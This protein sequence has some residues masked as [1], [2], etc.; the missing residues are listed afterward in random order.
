MIPSVNFHLWEPCNMRCKFCFAT[1]QD[2]KQSILPKGHLLKEEALS[3][4]ERLA[5]FGFQK[6]TFA[7]GEPTLCAWLPDLIAKAKDLGMTTMIVSNGSKL[8]DD[9]L[10]ENRNKLDWI[11]ISVDSVNPTIN[12]ETGRAVSGNTPL[13]PKD[14]KSIVDKVKRMGYG[15]KINTVVSSMN[16]REDMGAFI[17]YAQPERWKIL[18]VL[19]ILGQND[20]GIN[21]LQVSGQQFQMFLDTHSSLSDIT[22]IVPE[23]NDLVKGS[24]A[25][26]DPAGRFFDN[27]EG[28]HRYSGPILEIGVDKAWGG[29][30]YNF[31]RFVSRGGLY[32]W[33]R[34]SSIK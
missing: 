20:T 28:R 14:Y 23:T 18:Q 5:D 8:T 33:T 9:F 27:A 1:F 31:D 24:Y 7:G 16:F 22:K 25:M 4:V 15:L 19:P 11:A 30:H 12:T 21:G 29:V 32:D 13:L 17:R 34:T 3:V 26:V 6:I 2:V 10:K